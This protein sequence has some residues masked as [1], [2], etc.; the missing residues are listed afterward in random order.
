[1]TSVNKK[2]TGYR[3][4]IMSRHPS[5]NA[6][7]GKI[8]MPFRC[9]IRL[10]SE[11]LLEPG[12]V[13]LNSPEAARNSGS[14][15]R[16]KRLFQQAGVKT[17]EWTNDSNQA[18][19]LGFPLVAK[20]Y[21][22]SRGRGNHLIGTRE[23]FARFLINNGT[24]YI[25]EKFY[26]YNREY[27]IHVTEDGEFYSCRKMLKRDAPDDKRWQRHD[28]NC[29]WILPTNPEFNKP[30]NWNEIVAECVKA[31]KAIGADF[32]ACDVKCQ[33]S[34]VRRPNFIVLET[35]TGPSFGSITTQKYMEMIPKLL[36]KKRGRR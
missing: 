7:R 25:F 34:D 2:G 11:T 31:C 21:H 18:T 4:R 5:H 36:A 17:A 23:E 27:R 33:G 24:D 16:M 8:K 28:D 26:K 12:Y 19:N 22:G 13:T 15:L 9:A 14:K 6:L 32:C 20:S 3:L 30:D 10:G 35:N 1:M 29:V